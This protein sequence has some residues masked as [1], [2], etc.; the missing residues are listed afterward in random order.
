MAR[1]IYFTLRW[2]ALYIRCRWYARKNLVGVR[3]LP[4]LRRAW[5]FSEVLKEAIRHD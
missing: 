1:R 4:S 5:L 2:C 3:W